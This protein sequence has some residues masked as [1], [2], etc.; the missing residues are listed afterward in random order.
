MKKLITL[1]FGGWPW[2]DAAP[3]HGGDAA[4]F[5]RHGDG[6]IDRPAP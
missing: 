6:R 5:A 3:V 1:S 4:R 2:G